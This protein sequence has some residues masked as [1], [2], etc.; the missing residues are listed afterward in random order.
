MLPTPI[1]PQ[2]RPDVKGNA[3][4]CVHSYQ[5]A[6]VFPESL[7]LD[8]NDIVSICEEK[9]NCS[10]IVATKSVIIAPNGDAS[11]RY[12]AE[13]TTLVPCED[14]APKFVLERNM[15]GFYFVDLATGLIDSQKHTAFWRLMM[16]RNA[17]TVTAVTAPPTIT[18][19][20]HKSDPNFSYTLHSSGFQ[21]VVKLTT[22][23]D[24]SQLGRP[25]TPVEE[26]N[27]ISIMNVHDA[28]ARQVRTLVGQNGS[29]LVKTPSGWKT[30]SKSQLGSFHTTANDGSTCTCRGFNGRYRKCWHT[31]TV[32]AYV[33]R[34]RDAERARFEGGY[35]S[36][37]DELLKVTS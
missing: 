26:N 3:A 15:Y 9:A 2:K 33:R 18:Q 8:I 29:T 4:F 1:V 7:A 12:R 5:N 17:P 6:S 28:P 24:G 36:S 16:R 10:Y 31:T 22:A 25:A 34:Q 14:T 27:L 32:R 35:T 37:S 21:S 23:L 30:E 20:V 11:Q 13:Y 19:V